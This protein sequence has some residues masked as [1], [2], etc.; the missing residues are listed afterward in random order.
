MK[1]RKT[2]LL[3]CSYLPRDLSHKSIL[4]YYRISKCANEV[5][6]VNLYRLHKGYRQILPQETQPKSS[7]KPQP[8]LGFTCG[9]FSLCWPHLHYE[10]QYLVII[11]RFFYHAI[12]INSIVNPDLLNSQFL[13]KSA[14]SEALFLLFCIQ[15]FHYHYS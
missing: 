12:P 5:I 7:H 11:F 13:G 14:T 2:S 6:F 4:Y 8:S 15:I 3:V 9:Q 10:P 1:E